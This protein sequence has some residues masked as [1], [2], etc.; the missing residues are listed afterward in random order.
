MLV[1][2]KVVY[3]HRNTKDKQQFKNWR[4]NSKQ[5]QQKM[6][7]NELS[8]AE[9]VLEAAILQV[10]DETGYTAEDVFE[11]VCNLLDI[12]VNSWQFGRE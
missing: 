4:A 12:K 11:A 6:K 2:N 3:L 7:N 9:Q 10:Q 1:Q 8:Y 5:A